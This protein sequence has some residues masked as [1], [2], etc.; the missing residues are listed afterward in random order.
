M[1]AEDTKLPKCIPRSPAVL[2]DEAESEQQ[3]GLITAHF[4]DIRSDFSLAEFSEA[5]RDFL[6]LP[7]FFLPVPELRFK[8]L[9]CIKE[10]LS[11][12]LTR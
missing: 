9:F 12:V 10:L 1:I 2:G 6:T 11:A 8:S 5:Q 7:V 3:G 4:K